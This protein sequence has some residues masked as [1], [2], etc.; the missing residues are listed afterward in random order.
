MTIPTQCSEPYL[1][2]QFYVSAICVLDEIHGKI[3]APDGS[4]LS[5]S[6]RI[7]ARIPMILKIQHATHENYLEI[8]GYRDGMVVATLR[9]RA[10]L[11]YQSQIGLP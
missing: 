5:D 2:N 7:P 3:L 6:Q 4:V 9:E 1:E 8:I 11:L 10:S